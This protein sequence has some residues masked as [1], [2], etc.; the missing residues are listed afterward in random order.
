MAISDRS[1]EWLP[2]DI[3]QEDPLSFL[4]VHTKL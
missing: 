3:M 4:N 2:I 1:E